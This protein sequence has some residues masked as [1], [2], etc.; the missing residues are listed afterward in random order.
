MCICML[1]IT[2][3]FKLLFKPMQQQQQLKLRTPE[4]STETI[5]QL[6]SLDFQCNVLK[7]RI[8]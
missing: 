7:K 8:E 3:L 2:F 5:Q 6:N 1:Y 4:I